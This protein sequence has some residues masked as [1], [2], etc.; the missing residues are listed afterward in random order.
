MD[1]RRSGNRRTTKT[2][3]ICKDLDSPI[4]EQIETLTK[5]V[6]VLQEKLENNLEEYINEPLYQE[7]VDREGNEKKIS[8]PFVAEFRATLKEYT[9]DLTILSKLLEVKIEDNKELNELDNII[10]KIRVVK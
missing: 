7:I 10:Q 3:K 5:T 9:N 8:N 4:K 6:I 1:K 2:K